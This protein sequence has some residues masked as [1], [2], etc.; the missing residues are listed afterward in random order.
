MNNHVVCL[1]TTNYHPLPTRKQNVMNRLRNAEILYFD[2][3]VSFIAPLKDKKCRERLS[4]FKNGGE[5]V[6]ENITVYAL[7][8]VLPFFNK[9]RWINRLNQRRQAKFVREKMIKHGFGQ[10][11]ILWCYSPSS[12]DII[13]HL[14]HEKLVYD[15]VDR[16]SAYKG[17]ISPKVVDTMERDLAVAADQVFSTA[18]GLHE[19]LQQYNPHT[20]MIPNGAAYEIFSRVHTERDQLRCPQPLEGRAHP[21]FGFVGMLQECIDYDLIEQLAKNRP[22]ATIFFI[23]RTLPGVNLE[24]LKKYPNIVFHGLVP[25][26]EL[27]AYIAQFDVCLNVFR[28]GALSRDVSPLKFYEYLATG[29]PIVST[30]EPLQVE[31][32][33]D[34]VYIAH[35]AE[36]FLSLCDLASREKAPEKVSARLSYGKQC[37]WTERVHQM[38][39]ILYQNGILQPK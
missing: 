27:P 28:E 22:D 9:F 18:I 11:S 36:E 37:S 30:R 16:H 5:K 29:K 31:N 38:E 14:P 25:Q 6:Q 15:C 13:P 26:P 35:T 8:P 19:T 21:I 3:P 17:H 2:P 23:G 4:M 10:E 12:A 34:V 33:S 1:S 32:F 7:P 20:Q 24:H 39:G